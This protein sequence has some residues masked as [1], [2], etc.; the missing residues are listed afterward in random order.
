MNQAALDMIAAGA[1]VVCNHSGGKDSQA[2]Y[3]Q[4]AAIV[5]ADQLIVVHAD[6]PGVDWPGTI[7]HIEATVWHPLHV[8]TAGKTFLQMVERRGMFPSPTTRQ[9]TSD[10]KRDPIAK[11]VRH[12]LADHP[13]FGG[14]VI[15]A[16]G[17]RAEESSARSRKATWQISKRDSKA[18]RS[19]FN[20]LPIHDLLVDQVFAA[21]AAGG[22][23]PHY[24]YAAGMTRL[25]CCFCIMSSRADLKT[26]ARLRPG[27]CARIANLERQIGR[28][29]MMPVAGVARTLDQLVADDD[30]VDLDLA[31]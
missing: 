1:L 4:L 12:Y 16:M 9:C 23:E 22:Q 29:M 11:F 27:L 19:W 25:S 30:Q 20:W 18:G 15:S 7:E 8:V 31:A 2:M 10:L 21:I 13:R 5:P 3:L 17:L 6:L 14:Q 24:A 26:A 28:T